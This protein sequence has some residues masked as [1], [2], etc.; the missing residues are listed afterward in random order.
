M[1]KTVLITTI[2]I[3]SIGIPFIHT[4]NPNQ[5]QHLEITD[6]NSHSGLFALKIGK[7]LIKEGYHTLI[8]ESK[9]FAFHTILIQYERIINNLEQN[10]QIEEITELLKQKLRQANVIYQNLIPRQKHK[11]SIDILGS[12][13][14]S[15]SGNLD[16]QDFIT[17]SNQ[18]NTLKNS[19][20]VL[21]TENNEQVKINDLFEKRLNNL[22]KQSFRQA[23]EINRFIKQAR[24][25][26]DR[27]ID[28]QHMLHLQNIIFNIETVRYQLDTIFESIELSRLGV[29]SKAL[30]Y[31]TELEYATQLLTTEGIEISSYDQ[32][33]E[34]LE[35]V[36][37]HNGSS[38][39]LL[40]KIPK[41][42]VGNYQLLRLETIPIDQKVIQLNGTYAI[43]SETESFLTTEK[44]TQVGR[45]LLCKSKLGERYRKPMLPPTITRKPC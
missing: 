35:P 42:K 5:T 40:V 21:V 1:L 31:P 20:N 36:A 17:L 12:I 3:I 6:L 43:I 7:V 24:L 4:S 16:S 33:Y 32:T 18:I 22:T 41:F 44:C 37:F 11:R 8:H 45:N 19:N 28:W 10:P 26:L 15:I 23:V 14:K 25:N 9:L 29:I 38:I 39:I 27:A 34:Y 13:V 2:I 30:L